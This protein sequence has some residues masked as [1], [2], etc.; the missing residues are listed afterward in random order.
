MQSIGDEFYERTP[1]TEVEQR[2]IFGDGPRESEQPEARGTQV[3][4]HHRHDEERETERDGEPE[5][6]EKSVVGDPRAA[7][8]QSMGSIKCDSKSG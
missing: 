6:I 8:C 5:E 1:E 2:E 4:R 7:G 3:Q